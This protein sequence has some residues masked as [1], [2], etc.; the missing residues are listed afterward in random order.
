MSIRNQPCPRRDGGIEVDGDMEV[1][2]ITNK[3]LSIK[4]NTQPSN[5]QHDMLP[6]NP[7]RDKARLFKGQSQQHGVPA[8]LSTRTTFSDAVLR[9]SYAAGPQAPA[10]QVAAPPSSQQTL[11]SRGHSRHL[12]WQRMG[13]D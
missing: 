8:N 2:S 3:T 9:V 12:V 4:I 11:G 10:E 6:V 5:L 1:G 13:P 7:C